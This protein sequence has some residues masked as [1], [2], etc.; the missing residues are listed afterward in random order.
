MRRPVLRHRQFGLNYADREKKKRQPEGNINVGAQ[1]DTTI[2]STCSTAWSTSALP[3][4][5]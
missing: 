4:S 2:A 3:A 5:A 1:G